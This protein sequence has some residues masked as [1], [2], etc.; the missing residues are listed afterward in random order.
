MEAAGLH[1]FLWASLALLVLVVFSYAFRPASLIVNESTSQEK[2]TG[3]L[4]A[5][6]PCHPTS[7]PL[8]S[9]LNFPKFAVELWRY[10]PKN[11]D[12]VIRVV[13]IGSNQCVNAFTFATKL[14]ALAARASATVEFYMVDSW[15]RRGVE[16]VAGQPDDNNNDDEGEKCHKYC[17]KVLLDNANNSRWRNVKIT[18]IRSLSTQAATQFA[19]EFFDLVYVDALHTFA[20]S[21]TDFEAWYPKLRA[22]GLFAGDDFGDEEI[23]ADGPGVWEPLYKT[24]NWGVIRAATNMARKHQFDLSLTSHEVHYPAKI[25]ESLPFSEEMPLPNIGAERP[26]HP[27]NFYAVKPSALY[28][29][30]CRTYLIERLTDLLQQNDVFLRS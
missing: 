30:H 2:C 15:G 26:V 29:V 6:Q 25:K 27:P 1:R 16:A 21:T 14:S 20:A 3:N 19:D 18:M 11:P 7:I 12:S 9:R 17:R 22:G 4:H 23:A 8:L 5:Q 28:N 10:Q 24:Y 13:E